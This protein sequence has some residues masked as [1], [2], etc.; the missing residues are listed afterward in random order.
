MNEDLKTRFKNALRCA[1]M[2]GWMSHDGMR[3]EADVD[4]IF[5]RI[6]LPA[7]EG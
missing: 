5:D 2:A 7:G 1:W 6:L 3:I 4:A